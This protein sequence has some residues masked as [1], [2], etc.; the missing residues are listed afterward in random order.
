[1]DSHSNSSPVITPTEK[2]RPVGIGTIHA[3][4]LAIRFVSE[5]GLDVASGN[6]QRLNSSE[7]MTFAR[8]ERR[9]ARRE[10]KSDPCSLEIGHGGPRSTPSGDLAEAEDAWLAARPLPSVSSR[11]S[12]IRGPIPE[13]L[14]TLPARGGSI[15]PRSAALTPANRR[16][17]VGSSPQGTTLID[18][19][20]TD[21]KRQHPDGTRLDSQGRDRPA[22]VGLPTEGPA[23]ASRLGDRAASPA[24]ASPDATPGT[25]RCR[26]ACFLRSP[27][28]A[29][30]ARSRVETPGWGI[31]PP[32]RIRAA[33]V[34][35][36]DPLAKAEPQRDR[37]DVIGPWASRTSEACSM[38]SERWAC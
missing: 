26:S 31:R 5:P 29:S 32:P 34:S 38:I 1:M 20:M 3:F 21:A 30:A 36:R 8:P 24:W 6:D 23:A 35:T 14:A 13:L 16:M 19:R 33:S 9:F 12:R 17:F 22:L 15:S 25:A 28:I 7:P 4:S 2:S 10:S 27:R 18:F 11:G 37:R